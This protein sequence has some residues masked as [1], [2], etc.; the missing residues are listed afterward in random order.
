[1]YKIAKLKDYGGET[2][3][4]SNKLQKQ[5][6]NLIKKKKM[7]MISYLEPMQYIVKN[8]WLH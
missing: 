7:V 3:M 4:R 1:M 5:L 2:K 8:L 6:K